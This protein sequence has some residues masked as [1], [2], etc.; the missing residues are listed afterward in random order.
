M[1]A[2]FQYFMPSINFSEICN[3]KNTRRQRKQLLR[4]RDYVINKWQQTY[5]FQLMT[6]G[7]TKI[8]YY[9]YLIQSAYIL[10][11]NIVPQISIFNEINTKVL[12]SNINQYSKMKKEIRQIYTEIQSIKDKVREC[13]VVLQMIDT[14]H[15]KEMSQ[16]TN[17]YIEP[18]KL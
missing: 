2:S 18:F 14:C 7:R 1:A 3:I 5:A 17:T 10:Y 6:Y 13:I 8:D 12:I 4:R 16:F 11:N 15:I 9:N